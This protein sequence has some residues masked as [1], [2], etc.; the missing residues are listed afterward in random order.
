MKTHWDNESCKWDFNGCWNSEKEGSSYYKNRTKW[1]VWLPPSPLPGPNMKQGFWLI[2]TFQ[3]PVLNQMPQ[4]S[5]V[6]LYSVFW[7][8]LTQWCLMPQGAYC[9]ALP[10]PGWFQL[11]LCSFLFFFCVQSGQGSFFIHLTARQTSPAPVQHKLSPPLLFPFGHL[12]V[13]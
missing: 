7:K 11:V 4:P 3:Q 10:L 13:E 5:L 12:T 1:P 8:V 9:P 6:S 2:K